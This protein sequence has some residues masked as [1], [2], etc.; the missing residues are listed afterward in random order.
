[1]S[2]GE[3][4]DALDEL[5]ETIDRAAHA[6]VARVTGGLAPMAMA[7]AFFDW[8]TH[9][10]WAPGKNVQLSV[11]AARKLT[12]LAEYAGR[13]ATSTDTPTPCIEPLHQDKRFADPE[14]QKWPF[15][16]IQQGFLLQQQWWHN[17]TTGVPGV[18]KHHEQIVEFATRQLLDMVSPSNF[19]ATNPVVLKR[20]F[21]T[22]GRNF[23]EGAQN[24]LEDW[25][26]RATGDQ[27]VGA[28]DFR[29]GETVAVT[30]G[31]V[32]YRNRLIELIQYEP[33]TQ[34]VNAEPVLI[35]PAWIMKYYILDLSP[36]NS[37]VRFLTE[38]GFTVFM[39]S[40]LNPSAEDS[41]L[42][43]DDY[44]E[45]GVMAALDAINAIVPDRK[46]HATGY[47]LGGTLLSIAAATMARDGDDRLAS[48]TLFAGQVDFEEAGELTLFISE[49]QVRFLEDLMWSQGTLD[50]K[51]MA[52]AFELLR[53]NDLI[54]SRLVHSYLMGDRA[55]MSDL[56]AWNADATRMPAR[57]HSE[58]LRR[59]FLENDLSEGRFEVEGRPI[60]LSDIRAP[61]FAVGTEH[62]HVAPWRSVFK[63]HLYTDAD[64]TFALA[65]G[66][67]N[68]GIVAPPSNPKAHHRILE[69][70]EDGPYVDPDTWLA[71]APQ[72]DGSWWSAWTDWL[73]NH[74]SPDRVAPPTMGN[75]D[76]GYPPL[77][78]APGT[79]VMQK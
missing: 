8:G 5:A 50:S 62:D 46:I 44:R 26:R 64:V 2:D 49:S 6:S 79:Y 42:S 29:P 66:G 56:M 33:A 67:H 38:R 72:R 53:S 45:L 75:S 35:V 32:V 69:K 22:G 55:P 13:C 37:L 52:G 28:E 14:W 34:D 24:F 73:A 70:L 9:L 31:K 48:A 12:R 19:V 78:D 47:C 57:M 27:P 65:S 68:V 59:L 76:A 15:N 16:L 77:C 71:T 20:G 40:W 25:Q 3:K 36:E 41:E 23:L 7:S 43:I 39:V 51:Q 21:E 30:P 17:A 1:M 61:I 10:A 18:S 11:K 63:L 4:T 74:S 54:W 58:Y 60:A